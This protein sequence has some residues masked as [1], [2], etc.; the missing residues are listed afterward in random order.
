MQVVGTTSVYNIEVRGKWSTSHFNGI[1]PLYYI[2]RLSDFLGRALITF[3]GY[4]ADGCARVKGIGAVMTT[5]GVGELSAID[6]NSRIVLQICSCSSYRRHALKIPHKAAKR[7][8]ITVL[9]MV[10]SQTSTR[11]ELWRRQTY[12]TVTA[13]KEIDRVLQTC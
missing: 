8:G 10:I 7:V 1:A 4:A 12:S 13:P 11:L 5:F 9:V 6:A 3:V 2:H